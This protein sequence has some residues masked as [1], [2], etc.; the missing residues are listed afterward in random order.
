MKELI[1]QEVIE[2]KILMIRGKK[3]M[4]DKDLAKLYKV[5]TKYLTRQVRRNIGRFPDDFMFR[6]TKEENLRCQFGTSSYGGRRYLPYAFTEQGVSMLSSVI[7][8]ERAI[9]VNIAIMRAFVKLREILSVHKELSHK[10][11]ELEH[12]IE[13]HDVEIQAIFE[14]IRQLMEPPPE[15]PKRLIGFKQV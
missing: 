12:K 6:L 11:S 8:S 1:P 5:E 4:L 3:V 2:T 14:A 9:R 7:N 15:K 10:L 13:K